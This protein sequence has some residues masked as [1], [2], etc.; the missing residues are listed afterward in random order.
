MSLS[1]SATLLTREVFV[2]AVPLSFACQDV[3]HIVDNCF[4]PMEGTVDFFLTR[5]FEQGILRFCG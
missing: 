2:A 3:W 5:L 1:A 4:F